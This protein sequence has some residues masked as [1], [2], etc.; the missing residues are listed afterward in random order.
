MQVVLLSLYDLGHQPF[1]LASPAAW[2]RAQGHVVTCADHSI[3][4]LP[5]AEI[6]AADVVAFYL[7]MHTATRMAVPVIREVQKLNPRV[8]TIAYGLYAALNQEYLRDLGVSCTLGGEFERQLVAAIE[9]TQ[10]PAASISLE[11]LK[12][13]TP[14]R[15]GL[16]ILKRYPRVVIGHERRITGYTEASRGCKHLCRHC[17]IVPV[18]GGVFRVVGVET[19]LADIRQQVSSGAQHITFGDPD[20]FNGPSHAVR[21]VE[22]LH[23]E[24]PNLSYDVTIKIQ[25]LLDH[26][27]LLPVLAR[28]G[29]VLITSAVESLDDRVLKL[30]R[31][32]HT[33]ADFVK[34]L[35]L[36]RSHGLALA[37]TFIPFH[38]WTTQEA[39]ID[40]L[41]TLSELEL[42]DAVAP[43][44]LALRLL[45]TA[46]SPL[47]DLEDIQ[48][49]VA[50]FD[51]TSL[52][53]L[54][55][56]PDPEIETM[57]KTVMAI[58]REHARKRTSRR[59]VF[60]LI[61][62]ATTAARPLPGPRVARTTIPYLEEPW[63]C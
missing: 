34:A 13:L 44:Q 47:L 58:V 29:C 14:D 46:G 17:P 55:N 19:V 61:W 26:A 59:T 5:L 12:F 42:I 9:S 63:F 20:F 62:Q 60:E 3:S 41:S 21:I 57:A 45:I 48:N 52:S 39:Y 51:S 31:K 37:P 33:R 1:G 8:R 28:T 11:R 40:L 2:L 16:P 18:Y 15:T 30:L 22:A 4:A 38:P 7:P 56:H 27:R 23:S 50:G 10:T 25:H 53:H 24:F 36:V 32:G 49:V 54:W 6:R 35:R 43:V